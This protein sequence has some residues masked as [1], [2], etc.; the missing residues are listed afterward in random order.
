MSLVL[1][2]E[3]EIRRGIG[4]LCGPNGQEDGGASAVADFLR[5]EVRIRSVLCKEISCLLSSSGR[6]APGPGVAHNLTAVNANDEVVPGFE[7][8]I[9]VLVAEHLEATCSAIGP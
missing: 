9:I 7:R 3:G 6:N 5:E 1:E 4:Y 2:I 8:Y